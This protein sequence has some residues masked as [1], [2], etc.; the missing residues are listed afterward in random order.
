LTFV[1][2]PG[3]VSADDRRP[4]DERGIVIALGLTLLLVAVAAYSRWR[5]YQ[6]KKTWTVWGRRVMVPPWRA[7]AVFATI[8][9]AFLLFPEA[10]SV[11]N[12]VG[13]VVA[14]VV[15]VTGTVVLLG[16]M[17]R[18]L[19]QGRRLRQTG[20]PSF[21]GGLRYHATGGITSGMVYNA[22]WPFAHL[23]IGAGQ[24]TISL[25]RNL[26][27]VTRMLG[28][29]LGDPRCL[30]PDE[31]HEVETDFGKSLA[32][33]S[34]GGGLRF[35]TLDPADE[36]DGTVFWMMPGDRETII[37]QVSAAGFPVAQF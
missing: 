35:R 26:A 24:V 32:L 12:P 10:D 13:Q 33:L 15:L 29:N 4:S 19:R 23:D 16:D 6:G 7:V 27:F 3:T 1:A 21:T 25:S 2:D 34:G 31:V 17:A 14:G 11:T 5:R 30:R 37:R 22:T 18:S 9:V 28:S 36:R 8:A 20:A